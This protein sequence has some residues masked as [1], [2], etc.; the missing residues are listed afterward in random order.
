[1]KTIAV[2]TTSFL[3]ATWVAAFFAMPLFNWNAGSGEPV[4]NR[5][6]W[7]YWALTLPLTVVVM[8]CWY[9]W[10]QWRQR[11]DAENDRKARQSSGLVSESDEKPPV[12]NGEIG[13]A[14]KR[15][16]FG[17]MGRPAQPVPKSLA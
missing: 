1:M 12:A 7:V 3:P 8:L 11:K 4:L 10:M 14:S 16:G 15:Y 13:Y 2:L 9:T 17:R 5:W 6:F